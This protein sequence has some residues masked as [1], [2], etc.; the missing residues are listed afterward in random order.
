MGNL[1][2]DTTMWRELKLHLL[3]TRDPGAGLEHLAVP[4]DSE[5]H[6]IGGQNESVDGEVSPG[7]VRVLRTLCVV[8]L[9]VEVGRDSAERWPMPMSM[10]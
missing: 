2:Q 5:L 3:D 9:E 6:N 10:Y 1:H 4:L 8:E 7:Q